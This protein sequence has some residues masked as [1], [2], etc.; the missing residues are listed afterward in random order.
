M[1]KAMN[2]HIQVISSRNPVFNAG[3]R[4]KTRDKDRLQHLF[5][6]NRSHVKI[7]IDRQC[8]VYTPLLH[9]PTL[10]SVEAQLF[11]GYAHV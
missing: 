6:Q 5:L 1:V 2:A 10:S 8:A 11:F 4:Y 7:P 9:P 3:T